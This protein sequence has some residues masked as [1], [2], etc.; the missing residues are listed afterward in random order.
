MLRTAC[1]TL[2]AAALAFAGAPAVAADSYPDKPVRLVVPFSAGGGTDVVARALA[3]KFEKALGGGIVIDN[4]GGAGGTLG[5]ALVASAPPDGYTLLFTSASYVFN[6]SLYDN[7]PYDSAKDFKPVTNFA[8]TPHVVVVHPS[9]PVK[10]VKE[11]IALAKKR[12]G[13]INYSSGGR[14]SSVHIAAAYFVHLAKL[15][16]VH[17]PYKGGGPA[18]IALVSG[19]V[20]MMLPGMQSAIPFIRSGQMHALAVSS[21]KRSPALPKLP[22]VIEAGVPGFEKTAWFA[23]FAPAKV[24]APIIDK[25]YQAASKALRDPA[26]VKRLAADGAVPVGN[27]PAEFDAYIKAELAKWGRVMKEMKL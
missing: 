24:P 6:P 13:E 20:Q 22:T 21:K 11:L 5:T 3:E 1:S 27:T 26:I 19:E 23:L 17:V 9:M 2:F 18:M 4:R 12:P 16:V 7:L 10:S 14:G 15:N 25:L 8:D